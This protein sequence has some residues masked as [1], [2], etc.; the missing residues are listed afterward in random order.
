MSFD[1]LS[2]DDRVRGPVG[3]TVSVKPHDG[4]EVV[5]VIDDV[6]WDDEEQAW[7]PW[8]FVT[9]HGVPIEQFDVGDFSEEQLKGLGKTVLTRRVA[10]YNQI[11]KND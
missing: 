4:D 2:P 10:R 5:V 8:C 11:R 3:I 7:K 6:D 1:D 9:Q